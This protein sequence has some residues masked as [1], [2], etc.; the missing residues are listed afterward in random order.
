MKSILLMDIAIACVGIYMALVAVYMK[1]T[2][3]ISP[4]II[5][6]NEI[7]R[8]KKPKAYIDDVIVPMMVFGI[9]A[10]AIGVFAVL[11]DTGI[12]IIGKFAGLMELLCF[13]LALAG[14]SR[15]MKQAKNKYFP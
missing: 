15:Q 2:G 4:L 7:G 8:C 1:K 14:F 6:E 10:A 9:V 11:C 12:I 5:P 13:L 3:K